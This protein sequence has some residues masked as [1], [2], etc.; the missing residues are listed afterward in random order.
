MLYSYILFDADD[1]LFDYAKAEDYALTQSLEHYDI[2]INDQIVTAYQTIN[3]QL[4]KDFELGHISLLS[5]RTER[6]ERLIKDQSLSINSDAYGFSQRYLEHL[7]EASYMIDGAYEICKYIVNSDIN[8]AI[9]TNGIKEVQ[10]NRISRS[11][12]AGFIEEIIVSEDTGFQKPH[13]GIFDY[14]FNKLKLK[15]KNQV[16]I[17]GDSLT[18]DI[19]G[20]L[21]YGIDTC[22]FNPH[23]KVNTSEVL[24]T[25]EINS[26]IEIMDLIKEG[27]P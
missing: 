18:S 12:L 6:F 19:K 4:W 23:N 7:G 13:Q 3:K 27:R 20:G 2:E 14:T 10:M 17:I 26:L 1:T 21:D 22:W 8:I 11:P 24:P 16:V 15:D 5:L 25:Y 9:V